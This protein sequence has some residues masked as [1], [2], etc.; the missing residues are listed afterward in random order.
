MI[1]VVALE[2]KPR[3]CLRGLYACPAF[4]KVLYNGLEHLTHGVLDI[5]MTALRSSGSKGIE[6]FVCG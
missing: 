6:K 4:A 2:R 3:P 5:Q 1:G